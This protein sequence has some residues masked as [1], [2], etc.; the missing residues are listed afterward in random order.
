MGAVFC[1]PAL[2]LLAFSIALPFIV[3]VGVTFTDQR[4]LSP[5]ATRFVGLDNYAQLLSVDIIHVPAVVDPKTGERTYERLRT[6]LRRKE[7]YRGFRRL[8]AFEASSGRYAVVARD[9]IFYRSIFNT[10]LFV[11]WVIPLQCGLALALALLVN[12]QFPG[13]TFFRALYFAPVVTSMVVVSIVWS[14]LFN[15]HEGLINQGLVFLSGGLIDKVD[16][17]GD[18]RFAML[19]VVIMSAWQGTGFQ[20]LI[21][22]AGLQSIDPV[23][24]EAAKMDGA[25]RWERFIHVT[26]PG[27]RNTTVFVLIS[28]TI[29]AFGLFTQVDVMTRGGPN[30]STSTLIFHAVRSGYREQDIAYGSTIAVVFFVLVVSIALLQR[31]LTERGEA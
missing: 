2:A 17:L 13:R 24:Y 30:D 4:L 25:G 16:W 22:L 10:L 1:V 12:Q 26:L 19:A 21:F 7:G 9:P 27:L 11:A 6:V 8:V 28:T 5:N 31:V 3:A 14:L 20:M 15:T 23:L 29:A 18:E